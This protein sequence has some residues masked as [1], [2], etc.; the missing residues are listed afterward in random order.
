MME[1]S[2]EELIIKFNKSGVLF[3]D[4]LINFAVILLFIGCR[5][6]N[7]AYQEG[8]LLRLIT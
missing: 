3:F 8:V 5:F 4:L 6:G 7:C 1:H 2:E